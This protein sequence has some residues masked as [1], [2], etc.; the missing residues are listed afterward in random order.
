VVSFCRSIFSAAVVLGGFS[1]GADTPQAAPATLD[2]SVQITSSV[3]RGEVYLGEAI[4]LTLEYWELSVRG[5]KVQQLYR[6]GN[7]NPPALEGFY[8]GPL[9]TEKDDAVRDGVL[10]AVT[11][12]HQRIYPTVAGELE[13]GPWR[14]QGSVRGHTA[15]G[16]PTLS[17]DLS[18]D[19]IPV[20][21]LPLP[22][23]PSTFRGAVGEF[24]IEQ[25]LPVTQLTQGSPV[26]LLV[27]VNG[28]GNPGTLEAPVI[29][30]APWFSVDGAL[31]GG[32]PTPESSTGQ[33]SRQ[34]SYSLMPLS[35]GSFNIPAVS[36]TYFSPAAR[37]Y[38]SVRTTPIAVTVK[39][40]GPAESLVVVGGSANALGG[41]ELMED[42]RFALAEGS[43]DFAVQ[44]RSP[45]LWALLI[46]LPPLAWLI[47]TLK[48]GEWKHAG[49]WRWT[50]R[51]RGHLFAQFQALADHPQP[52]E[53]LNGLLCAALYRGLGPGASG[54][55]ASEL[56]SE[57]EARIGP[58]E[59]NTI[60]LAL[61]ACR[62][63][64]FGK[65]ALTAERFGQ[66]VEGLPDA[67]E[68]L[69]GT[70]VSKGGGS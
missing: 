48:D 25:A 32:A 27:T 46:A 63:H 18:T 56:R 53:A 58:E 31:D 12:H 22:A 8:A 35:P 41:P 37:Q 14:W 6:G 54:L 68:A 19:A 55:A 66:V 5:L 70:E 13:I 65:E 4:N 9:V 51:R 36:L 45:I 7:I 62:D 57:L 20:R 2:K 44:Q 28:S 42:G 29:P 49:A 21:V 47:L 23:P 61:E 33:F 24:T 17:L 67:L 38:K 30:E 60:V 59:V 50:R 26:T 1:A 3:D 15:T 10:Y 40:S 64:R 52:V 43:P 11:R 34:F 16:N 69:Q 39:E